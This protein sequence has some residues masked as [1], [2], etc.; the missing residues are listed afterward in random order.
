MSL[1]DITINENKKIQ[2]DI[3]HSLRDMYLKTIHEKEKTKKDECNRKLFEEKDYIEKLN[4]IRKDQEE[5]ALNDKR[6]IKSL[7][8]NDY[9]KYNGLTNYYNTINA[10]SNESTISNI[11]NEIKE[12]EVQRDNR[13][14]YNFKKNDLFNLKY[15]NT[16]KL[17]NDL[18]TMSDYEPYK[19][20]NL[21]K[22]TSVRNNNDYHQTLNINLPTLNLKNDGLKEFSSKRKNNETNLS[23]K[24]SKDYYKDNKSLFDDKQLDFLKLKDRKDDN[25]HIKFGKRMDNF[26]DMGQ[27]YD[28][29]MS[30]RS[31]P[32][33][34]EKYKYLKKKEFTYIKPN[35]SVDKQSFYLGDSSLKQNPIINPVNYF[36]KEKYSKYLRF[37][38]K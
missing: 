10:N 7:I 1:I 13:G 37:I 30:G 29:L 31:S 35:E 33:N 2:L 26:T 32:S 25:F 5:K 14:E 12:S 11:N 20:N 38:A 4:K 6:K 9:V 22:S 36:D 8:F 16:S 17:V 23:N 19:Q 28:S 24:I 34:E 27:Y 15:S 3:K 21:A 18:I